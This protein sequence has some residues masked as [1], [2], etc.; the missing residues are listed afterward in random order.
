MSDKFIP[1]ESERSCRK[2]LIYIGLLVF[3]ALVELA[4]LVEGGHELLYDIRG[5]VHRKDE[6]VLASIGRILERKRP[7]EGELGRRA[8][9]RCAHVDR[10]LSREL[11]VDFVGDGQ[12]EALRAACQR[13]SACDESSEPYHRGVNQT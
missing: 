10:S 1:E 5:G 11:K 9:D 6:L 4:P 12:V 3:G 7:E 13:Q 2:R 8:A